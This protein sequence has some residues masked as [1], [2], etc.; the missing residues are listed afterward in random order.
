MSRIVTK[1]TKWH[2]R[3]AKTQIRLGI[4]VFIVRM[5]KAKVLSYPLSA[6]RR[7]WSDWADAQAHLSLH[8]AHMPFC[9]FCHEAAQMYC[10]NL[11]KCTAVTYG[12]FSILSSI[13][14]K[15][16][17]DGE[18]TQEYFL[19]SVWLEWTTAKIYCYDTFWTFTSGQS[20]LFCYHNIKLHE[21]LWYICV[22]YIRI[23][24]KGSPYFG[25]YCSSA[26]L[27]ILFFA[28]KISHFNRSI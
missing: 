17:L 11:L 13:T 25:I 28:K 1:P 12:A 23:C 21:K 6:Q 27:G 15:L 19:T 2:V 8:W 9:W 4:R 24:F 3:P 26:A 20:A 22:T 10:W 5:K 14:I 18:C 16:K 7:L